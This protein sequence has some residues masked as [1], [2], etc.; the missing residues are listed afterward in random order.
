MSVSSLHH[1]AEAHESQRHQAGGHQADGEA[2]HA[3]GNLAAFQTLAHAGHQHDRQGEAQRGEGAVEHAVEQVVA[4]GHVQRGHAQ[5]RAVGG[6]EGQIDTQRR[7][8]GRHGLF[9][10]HFHE[11]NQRRNHQ[12][13]GDGLHVFQAQGHQNPGIDHVAEQ[14]RNGHD[15]GNGHAHA[16]SGLHLAAHAQEGAAAQKLGENKVV[17]KYRAKGDSDDTAKHYSVTSFFTV[18]FLLGRTSPL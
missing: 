14:R 8:D 5:H 6:D 1:A 17:Y 15:E 4:F 11:L 3:S 2:L 7:V 18:F 13:E 12:N 16:G 10:E 9:Q